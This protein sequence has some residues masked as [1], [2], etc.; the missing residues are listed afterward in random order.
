[1]ADRNIPQ[2]D[3]IDFYSLSTF[4]PVL[5]DFHLGEEVESVP[6]PE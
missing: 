3:T 6:L 1:M 2:R 5:Y 4:Q